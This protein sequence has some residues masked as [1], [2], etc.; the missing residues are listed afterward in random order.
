MPVAGFAL[1]LR[2]WMRA[3]PRPCQFCGVLMRHAGEEADDEHLD[4]GQQLQGFLDSVDYNVWYCPSCK[5]MQINRYINWLSS[6]GAVRNAGT[7]RWRATQL[8]CRQPPHP[9]LGGSGLTTAA[10]IVGSRIVKQGPA[11]EVSRHQA[12]RLSAVVVLR[13]AVRVAVG[14]T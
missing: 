2:S 11:T 8:F 4:G 13:E 3:R 7:R 12:V 1:W 6:Y 14:E 10:A 5:D 9:A